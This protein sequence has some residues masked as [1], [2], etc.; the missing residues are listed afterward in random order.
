VYCCGAFVGELGWSI[1]GRAGYVM[2]NFSKL[3][4]FVLSGTFPVGFPFSRLPL[5]E[6][7]RS[8]QARQV[9]RYVQLLFFAAAVVIV[10][11]FL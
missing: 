1:L 7:L 9:G 5:S 2:L 10:P 8:V 6:S 3:L 11:S 4:A